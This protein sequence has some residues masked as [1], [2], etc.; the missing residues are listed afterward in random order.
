MD[1]AVAMTSTPAVI[2]DGLFLR[3]QEQLDEPQLVELTAL[4]ALENH[5]ARFNHAFGIGS[6]DFSE[7]QFCVLPDRTSVAYA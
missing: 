3:L 4:I 1:Y 7:G 6:Q 2:P 5:R